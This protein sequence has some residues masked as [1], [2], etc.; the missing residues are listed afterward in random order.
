MRRSS[1][2]KR[3]SANKSRVT[4]PSPKKERKKWDDNTNDP[5]TNQPNKPAASTA[6]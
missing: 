1:S 6:K 2:E 5:S 4:S 3:L